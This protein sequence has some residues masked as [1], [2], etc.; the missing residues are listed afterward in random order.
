[1]VKT[2]LFYIG[3][4]S[5]IASAVVGEFFYRIILNF[6]WGC[7]QMICWG[8]LA[9]FIRPILSGIMCASFF[10]WGIHRCSKD[11]QLAEYNVSLIIIGLFIISFIFSIA[12]VQ[13]AISLT[14][15]F[16]P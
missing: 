9:F 13:L 10:H 2:K 5:F 4:G 15:S 16:W 3:V 12:Y 6:G 7:N 11:D 1:M 14:G 8:Y